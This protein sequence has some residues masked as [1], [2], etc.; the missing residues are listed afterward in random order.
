[1]KKPFLHFAIGISLI[2]VSSTLYAQDT[3]MS[4]SSELSLD[5]ILN[6]STTVAAKKQLTSRESP[7]IVSVIT[8]DEI[9][10]SG[11]RD[12]YDVL[13]LLVPGFSFASDWE[14]T[15]G[16]GIRGIYAMEGKVLMLVDGHDVNDEVFANTHY[17]NRYPADMIEKVEV[18]RGP[19]S[20][21]YGGF[22]GVGVISVT[23]K[24]HSG[25]GAFFTTRHSQMANGL[26][27]STITGGV[28]KQL[29]EDVFVGFYHSAGRGNTSGRQIVDSLDE[30]E[31]MI[32]NY[33]TDP[34][35]L[36]TTLKFK[37]LEARALM[38][39]NEISYLNYYSNNLPRYATDIH[40]NYHALL[41]YNG[42]L[43]DRLT[44]TPELRY[45]DQHPYNV[46]LPDLADGEGN[47]DPFFNH[48]Q[49]TK[50]SASFTANA[51]ITSELNL[52]AGLEHWRTRENK[53]DVTVDQKSDMY[54]A[55][56]NTIV[57][58]QA[59]Y[60][61]PIANITLGGRFESSNS[62]DSLFVPRVGLNKVMGDFHAKAMWAKAFRLP[63][64]R[65]ESPYRP[66]TAINLEVEAG[67]RLSSNVFFQ[68]NY[69][70]IH[71]DEVIVYN[72]NEGLGGYANEGKQGTRGVE[73]ELRYVSGGHSVLLNLAGYQ[74]T[75]VIEKYSVPEHD[76][77]YFAM[78]QL[79]ANFM[80]TYK[81]SDHFQV[82]PSVQYYG[83]KFGEDIDA[84]EAGSSVRE[85]DPSVIVNL[86]LRFTDVFV[87]GF[88]ISLGGRNL[89]NDDDALPMA[90]TVG[91]PNRPIPVASR[92]LDASIGYSM[93]F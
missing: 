19:G 35:V 55:Y 25:K 15:F 24:A 12:L 31:S 27:S 8:E 44:I 93:Q 59:M 47:P 67:Y 9:K 42:K 71:F 11:A 37:D 54:D 26:A 57:F 62:F 38:D 92:S 34:F 51:E 87:K 41:R 40:T 30:S 82:I 85:F 60:A 79:R 58:G 16:P 45:K 72:G 46:R 21:I 61:N 69:Y 32:D 66:E 74:A 28:S 3:A 88:E 18:I 5:D 14:N 48:Y 65:T 68:A 80:A 43:S 50:L 2:A 78:P 84:S 23:T 33:G 53:A 13:N 7:G 36:G 86:N 56:Q 75:D 83:K 10:R 20:S 29:N 49:N 91:G 90:Y 1:M 89:L 77:L 70:D 22:A 81:V 64:F 73:A 76:D 4:G 39:R 6:L 52:V 17:K 63:P